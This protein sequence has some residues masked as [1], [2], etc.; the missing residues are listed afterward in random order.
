MKRK[1]NYWPAI[2]E[3]EI[4]LGKGVI[5]EWTQLAAGQFRISNK[6]DIYPKSKK[7]FYIPKQEWGEYADL[8][9]LIKQLKQQ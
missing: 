9:E 3:L 1:F 4:L 8:E 6:L 5:L 2:E 7:Y